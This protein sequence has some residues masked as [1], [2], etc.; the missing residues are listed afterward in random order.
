MCKDV[1]QDCKTARFIR[2]LSILQC[3]SI[4]IIAASLIIHILCC[5]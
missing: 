3:L 4:V 5:R 1:D 2:R